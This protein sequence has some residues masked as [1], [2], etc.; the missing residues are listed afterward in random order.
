MT[1]VQTEITRNKNPHTNIDPDQTPVKPPHK[2]STIPIPKASEIFHSRRTHS[3][4]THEMWHPTILFTIIRRLDELGDTAADIGRIKVIGMLTKS[5]VPDR[6]H[7][8]RAT[9]KSRRK[10]RSAWSTIEN[11]KT[12]YEPGLGLMPFEG[13][14]FCVAVANLWFFSLWMYGKC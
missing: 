12:E 4:Y 6:H 8:Y 10:S 1:H 11:S 5:S 2:N 14:R 3:H 13:R 9:V 7:H